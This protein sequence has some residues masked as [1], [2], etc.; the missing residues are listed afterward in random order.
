[1]ITR[2]GILPDGNTYSIL[3]LI[4]EVGQT[5]FKEL[6]IAS[7]TSNNGLLFVGDVS[8]QPIELTSSTLHFNFEETPI[9]E[10]YIHGTLGDT[11]NVVGIG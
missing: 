11:F 10:L 5:H 1:M 2:K 8:Q 6:L 3:E 4:G 7:S 9:R